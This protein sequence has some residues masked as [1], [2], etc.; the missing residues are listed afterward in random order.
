MAYCLKYLADLRVQRQ[1]IHQLQ[2]DVDRFT[3]N[4]HYCEILSQEYND[5]SRELEEITRIWNRDYVPSIERGQTCRN[6]LYIALNQPE[7][8]RRLISE[9]LADKDSMQIRSKIKALQDSIVITEFSISSKM[10]GIKRSEESSDSAGESDS[11]Q[12][13]RH[14]RAHSSWALSTATEQAKAL[15]EKHNELAHK[16][17]NVGSRSCALSAQLKAKKEKINELKEAMK[18]SVELLHYELELFPLKIQAYELYLNERGN[19]KSSAL[20]LNTAST[21]RERGRSAFVYRTEHARSRSNVTVLS[22]PSLTTSLASTM[23]DI[24]AI[25]TDFFKSTEETLDEITARWQ[26]PSYLK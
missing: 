22:A 7:I 12:T 14:R 23:T 9:E 16:M 10:Q 17:R 6:E 1:R 15:E 3:R 8:F 19:S 20:R 11:T 13:H 26:V 2:H 24:S 18:H 25:G 21:Q 5:T 4:E